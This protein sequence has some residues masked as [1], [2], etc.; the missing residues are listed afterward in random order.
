MAGPFGGVVAMAL[1]HDPEVVAW[2]VESTAA[3]GVPV[4]VEEPAAVERVVTLLG[5]G[6]EPVRAARSDRGGKGRSGSDPERPG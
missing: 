4:R 2:V 5:E 3:Q 1:S 6:R